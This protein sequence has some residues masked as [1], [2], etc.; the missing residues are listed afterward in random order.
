MVVA[1]SGLSVSWKLGIA[2]GT[3]GCSLCRV[4][5]AVDGPK[6]S[7]FDIEGDSD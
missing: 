5:G 2:E 4:E 3:G 6:E 7:F 1:V